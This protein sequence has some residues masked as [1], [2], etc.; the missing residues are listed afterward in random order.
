MLEPWLA[1]NLERETVERA[2][3]SADPITEWAG[4]E[5]SNTDP[6]RLLGLV[7]GAEDL[8]TLMALVLSQ[9]ARTPA[10]RIPH[11][12]LADAA[13]HL[14]ALAAERR[15]RQT[16]SD[17]EV[18]V[19][20]RRSDGARIGP[21]VDYLRGQ[22]L[23][24]FVDVLEIGPGDDIVAKLDSAIRR[25]RC[26]I[27]FVSRPYVESTWALRELQM[28]LRSENCRILPVLLDDVPLPESIEN[29]CTIDLRGFEGPPDHAVLRELDALVRTCRSLAQE[30]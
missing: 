5:L 18:F 14:A 20:Y 21:L 27:V 29:V 13:S 19:S 26:G 8:A 28:L 17:H 11:R 24:L 3:S 10:D 12:R 30:G 2:S 15:A 23:R 9:L 7:H 25:A 22:G 16:S 1:E 4:D 6:E